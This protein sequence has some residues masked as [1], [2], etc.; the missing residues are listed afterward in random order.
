MNILRDA[1]E[2]YFLVCVFIF[3]NIIGIFNYIINIYNI[4]YKK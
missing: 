4:I 2:L 1:I 3:L